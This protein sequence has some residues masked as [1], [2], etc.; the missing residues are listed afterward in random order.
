MKQ[1]TLLAILQQSE[2]DLN[3]FKRWYKD[4][5]HEDLAIKPDKWTAKL[6]L[7]TLVVGFLPFLPELQRFILATQVVQPI[8]QSIRLAYYLAASTKLFL[9]R[10]K[11][12][13]VVAIAG[14]YGKTSTKNIAAHALS[15]QQ[16]VLFTPKSINTLLGIAQVI[17]DD[18][19]A[20]HNVF[21]VEFGEYNDEDVRNLTNFTK[22][23]LAILTPIGRQHLERFGS[24][25]K[26]TETFL[27]LI[28][29]FE[30]QPEKLLVDEKNKNLVDA[31]LENEMHYTTYGILSSSKLRLENASISR[32]GTEFDT[33]YKKAVFI[34]LYGEHQATNALASIWLAEKLNL[35]INNAIAQLATLP[36]VERRHEPHFAKNNVLILDNSYNTNPDSAT[37]SLRLINELEASRRLIITPG[38]VEL[39]KASQKIH[40]T[41]GEQLAASVDYVGLIEAP[42]TEAIIE[43]FTKAGGKRDHMVI[44]KDLDGALAKLSGMIIPS[45]IVLFEGGFREVY[46]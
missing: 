28:T 15:N 10:K 8:D 29:F 45:S 12:L 4:H 16:K 35:N 17:L 39:G 31:A 38:F 44:G 20:E 25:E 2:Y 18:L 34:P 27:P 41:F 22:P 6:K 13:Q 40:L 3:D 24:I 21:I 33:T 26:I 36:Y 23:D 46:T 43:G 5:K 19:K 32:Q 7:I 14:S 11:G 9:L 37:F 30:S 42:W 1:N